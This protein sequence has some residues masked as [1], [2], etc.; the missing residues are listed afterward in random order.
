MPAVA[1]ARQP[2]AVPDKWDYEADVVVAGY[3]AAGCSAA[4][5][6]HDAGAKVLIIEKQAFTGGSIR[7]CGGGMYGGPT[8]L[9]KTLGVE[10]SVDAVYETLVACLT[11]TGTDEERIRI[12]A[13]NCGPN[14]DWVIQELGGEIK[15][16]LSMK[17]AIDPGL[18][19]SNLE[20]L[21][22]KALHLPEVGRSHWFTPIP[23]FAQFMGGEMK[24]FE[25]GMPGGSGLF[26]PFDDAVQKR[27]IE[28]LLE[29]GLE[30]LIIADPTT[31]EVL[32]VKAS[33]KGNTIYI[34]ANKAVFLGTGGFRQNVAMLKDYRPH[35][36]GGGIHVAPDFPNFRPELTPNPS[37][38][39]EHE[40]GSG[41]LAGMAIGAGV[42][43][44]GLLDSTRFHCAGGLVINND[45][46]VLDVFGNVI[47]RLYASGCVTG[48]TMGKYY[49]G[50]GIYVTVAVCFGRI[51]G[52]NAAAETPVAAA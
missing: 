30:E 16:K 20:E 34:K 24:G 6:A 28:T 4:I 12:I 2:L 43:N 39:K 42:T 41:V 7:R 49:P 22:C 40:D 47:P 19:V 44:M 36:D 50:C 46:R 27:Q 33:S 51:A 1:A 18:N 32:G 45:A 8:A 13:E 23:E 37:L 5:E 38:L 3:G 48:G 9:Q 26:K 10:D 31:R 29:T 11:P 52:K 21:A 14:I 25:G 17:Y 15:E 35:E